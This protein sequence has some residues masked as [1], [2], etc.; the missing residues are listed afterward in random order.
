MFVEERPVASFPE[1]RRER[2]AEVAGREP[3]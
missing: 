2:L 1:E 3:A